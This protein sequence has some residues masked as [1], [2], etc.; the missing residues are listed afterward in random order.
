MPQNILITGS[1]SGFGNL[2]AKTLVGSGHRVIATMR[3]IHGRNKSSAN[4]LEEL[5][6]TVLDLDVT[7]EKTVNLAI[8]GVLQQ[9]GGIDVV[10]NNAGIGAVGVQEAFTSRGLVPDF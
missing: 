3:D 2:T 6:A 1:S 4:E 8:E 5:G 7:Q 10:I 9:E